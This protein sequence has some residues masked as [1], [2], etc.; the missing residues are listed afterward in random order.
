MPDTALPPA[1]TAVAAMTPVLLA[2]R[3]AALDL[4]ATKQAHDLAMAAIPAFGEVEVGGTATASAR[5]GPLRI[6]AWNLER[7]L[8]PDDSAALL[9]AQGTS[10]VLLTE[11]DL[12]CHRT[13]QRH[14]TRLLAEGLGHGYA[15]GLEF[16]E[17]WTMPAPI[18]F[19]G[20]P[21]ES[22]QGFHGNGFTSALP[23]EKPV[24][25]HFAEEA[26]WFVAPKGG[27]RR[28][29]TR[30]AIAATFRHGDQKFVACSVHLES[31]ADFAGR[32]RQMR[33]LYDALDEIAEGLPVIIGGDLNTHV[34][35]GGHVDAQE[36]LFESGRQRGYDWASANV[37][38]ASTR[39]STWATGA[40]ERQLD[41]FCTRGCTAT[42]PRM[43][44]GV[45][46]DGRVLTDHDMISIEVSFG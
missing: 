39:P 6:A 42:D 9:R 8:F 22:L 2:R 43:V 17:L 36:L 40:G 10:L 3:K 45:A 32:D 21:S 33:A 31:R 15:F 44:P 12:G 5:P 28:I 18:A 24:V 19:A 13:G 30:M 37:A 41:W 14:T 34:G 46:P 20:N 27:Q 7:C 11:M 25:I 35:A 26:D 38:R 23:F 29:G 4:P 1:R 16:V